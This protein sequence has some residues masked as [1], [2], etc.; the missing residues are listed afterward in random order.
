MKK[1]LKL[2]I[3]LTLACL[4]F[5]IGYK[6]LLLFKI[7][8][9]TKDIKEFTKDIHGKIKEDINITYSDGNNIVSFKNILIS[10]IKDGK[11]IEKTN[12]YIVFENNDDIKM[13]ITTVSPILDEMNL[14]GMEKYLKNEN[15]KTD[16]DVYRFVANYKENKVNLFSSFKELK[17]ELFRRSFY[18][19]ASSSWDEFHKITGDLTGYIEISKDKISYYIYYNDEIYSVTFYNCVDFDYTKDIISTIKF[20]K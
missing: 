1:Y 8:N 10:N 4:M 6:G 14:K 20:N 2:V 11:E 13:V 18:F 3:Y 12:E 5:V 17:K 9:V 15:I 19:I 16:E 7:G